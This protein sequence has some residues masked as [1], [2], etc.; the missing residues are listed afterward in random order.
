[1]PTPEMNNIP[2]MFDDY[3]AQSQS[4]DLQEQI[5]G[6][7]RFNPAFF[8]RKFTVFKLQ[9][10]SDRIVDLSDPKI[11]MPTG[12]V[13][14]LLDDLVYPADMHSDLPRLELYPLIAREQFMK[15]IYHVTKFNNL[16]PIKVEDKY[17]LKF[18]GLP[19]ALMHFR[20]EHGNKF[21]YCFAYKDL[22]AKRQDCLILI[23]HNPIFR[24]KLYGR[25]RTF[26]RIQL[27]LSSV[28]NTVIDVTR[29]TN[30]DQYVFIPWTDE[31]FDRPLFVRTKEALNIGTMRKPESIQY[32]LQM[33]ILNFVHPKGVTSIFNQI[34]DELLDR[35]NLVLFTANG[36]YVFYN[37]RMLKN[38]RENATITI[39]V[40]NQLNTLAVMGRIT[41]DSSDEEKK[42]V[43]DHI[44]SM[45]LGLGDNPG[46]NN[47]ENGEDSDD[48]ATVTESTISDEIKNDE[49][50]NLDPEASVPNVR[51]NKIV[52]VTQSDD[53]L[54]TDVEKT[55]V[56]SALTRE[57]KEEGVLSHLARKIM[58]HLTSASTVKGF[59]PAKSVSTEHTTEVGTIDTQTSVK[60]VDAKTESSTSE[61][62]QESDDEAI[63]FLKDRDDLTPKQKERYA[64]MSKAYK[65][66]ELN[67][68]KFEKI[69]GS[70]H[71][72]SIDTSPLPDSVVGDVPT[73][74]S[75]RNCMLRD[76]DK[77]FIRKTYPKQLAGVLSSFRRVGIY[78]TDIKSERVQTPLNNDIIYTCKYT[79]IKGKSSTVKLKLPVIDDEGR[80]FVDGIYKVMK[81][82]R[83]DLPI[84]KI[85]D[86][87]VSLSSNYNKYRVIRNTAKAHD[88]FTYI[89][90]MLSN[91]RANVNIICGNNTDIEEAIS[92]DYC[93]VAARYSE[94]RWITSDTKEEVNLYFA[95]KDRMKA[96][97]I[98]EAKFTTL[99]KEYGIYFGTFGDRLLFVDKKNK[100]YAVKASGAEDVNFTHTS[101]T[102]VFRT[103]L[104]PDAKFN[105]QL[106]E[107]TVMKI[108][109][110][111]LPLM[112]IL[113]YRFGLLK[114][115][116]HLH[117]KYTIT[118]RR[119]KTILG[120]DENSSGT[121]SFGAGMDVV[122]G[123]DEFANTEWIVVPGKE[124]EV[125]GTEAMDEVKYIPKPGDI[126][127]KFA[128]R[129]LW[130]NRYPLSKSLILAGLDNFDVSDYPMA[131]FEG[132]EVYYKLLM[133]AGKSM[134]Y[135]KGIDS[136]FDLFMD[137]ITFNVLKAMHEPTT[138]RDLLIRATELLTTTDHRQASSNLNHRIR[139]YEQFTAL[140][141]NELSR[142]VANYQSARGA[143]NSLSVNPEAV[144]LRIVTNASLIPST[145]VN[146]LQSI[147]EASELTHAGSGGRTEE[148]FVVNDRKFTKD[149]IGVMA[150]DTVDNGKV[151]MSAILTV[152]SGI[153]NTEGL[154]KP[155]PLKDLEPSDVLSIHSLTFP[156]ALC[157]DTKR[158]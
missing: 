80:I 81:K 157:D 61:F 104:L 112:F 10:F 50:S 5:E 17:I 63:E 154:T 48:F 3:L 44:K 100:V 87:E 97:N 51:D 136:F 84:V 52:E 72:I 38:F 106:T 158:I 130:F 24:L 30:K 55:K 151:G 108:L 8:A 90:S 62:N 64:Q 46:V 4:L 147:K 29:E 57:E 132:K 89:D 113:S 139:G 149:D 14:H 15:F 152:N 70:E 36:K 13:M 120:A 6:Q 127:I 23:N 111:T 58:P 146:P 94:V 144:Y 128:D 16:N 37:L 150:V 78:L 125:V 49:K 65:K 45:K 71:D 11:Q 74:P 140:V 54:A 145:A 143:N 110:A 156:F 91:G 88:Y 153:L 137:P 67:G 33:H 117:A 12:S 47:T 69:L 103:A 85:S 98:P 119:A 114:T 77:S 86:T 116:D 25:M 123:G 41:E 68:Q 76:Y 101:I 2:E 115:L 93:A 28:L 35:I 7:E 59:T 34:P 134:N 82:Q 83:I 21:K 18:A 121:E 42:L 118:E 131:D 96:S 95:Y 39:R 40:C 22:P 53:E 20:A 124:G 1:M 75:I 142:Q 99:E 148:S 92:Y 31:V 141:Y 26:R 105:K 43:E 73:D 155:K 56:D 60:N 133:D 79:D 126:A 66:L 109:D 19:S 27:L 135:I 9:H 32:L 129:T 102:E 107:W 122:A 138:P